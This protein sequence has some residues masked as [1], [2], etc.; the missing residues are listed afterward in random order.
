MGPFLTG[1]RR[2]GARIRP[3]EW[4][5]YGRLEA[6]RELPG[7]PRHPETRI[8]VG[9]PGDPGK[10]LNWI[11][12]AGFAFTPRPSGA[13]RGPPGSP[14]A[15][16]SILGAAKPQCPHPHMASATA[17]RSEKS[18]NYKKKNCNFMIFPKKSGVG[19][20]V[21]GGGMGDRGLPEA[22]EGPEAR[23]PMGTPGA[24]RQNAELE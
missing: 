13:P 10:I 8:P 19:G 7:A 15:P 18:W 24:P 14:G 20:P 21:E 23:D 22:L 1:I 3:R 4:R 12:C 16:G 5:D 6:P 17:F 9:A 11:A 2:F